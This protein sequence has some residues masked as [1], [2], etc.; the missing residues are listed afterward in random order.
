MDVFFVVLDFHS[1]LF[2]IFFFCFWFFCSLFSSGLPSVCAK[3]KKQRRLDGIV[4][5]VGRSHARTADCDKTVNYYRD[6]R[7][8]IGRHRIC[9]RLPPQRI[10]PIPATT[11]RRV[12]R[13]RKHSN[14]WARW[15]TF[16]YRVMQQIHRTFQD[17][18]INARK[19]QRLWT[20]SFVH[21]TTLMQSASLDSSNYKFEFEAYRESAWCRCLPTLHQRSRSNGIAKR[22]D[23]QLSMI[24]RGAHI[25]NSRREQREHEMRDCRNWFLAKA[26]AARPATLQPT[27]QLK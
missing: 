18:V 25:T 21:S 8:S 26:I 27:I 17:Q 22:K 11:V 19:N 9:R 6:H 10:S 16:R 14:G 12:H 20:N 5:C 13:Q 3:N 2:L 15:V 23:T 24:S 4:N 7:H 1:N